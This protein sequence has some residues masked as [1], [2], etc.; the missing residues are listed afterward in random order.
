MFE[1][2]NPINNYESYEKRDDTHGEETFTHTPKIDDIEGHSRTT[3]KPTLTKTEITPD[4]AG[5]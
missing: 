5:T 3:S 2:Y 4:A 1:D